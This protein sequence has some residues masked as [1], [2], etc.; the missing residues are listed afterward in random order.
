MI[1]LLCCFRTRDHPFR[2][3]AE[4]QLDVQWWHEFL[5]SWH[6]VSFWLFPG[7]SD[8]EVTSD[9][10]GSLGFGA[11]FNNEWFSGAWVPSQADQ[12]I[13]YKERFPVVV[14]AHVWVLSGISDMLSFFSLTMRPLYTSCLLGRRGSHA[15]WVLSVIYSLQLLVLILLSNHSIS[16]VFITTLLMLF[17]AFVGRIFGVWLPMHS[18]SQLQLLISSGSS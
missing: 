9:P 15:L 2:L 17:P 13:A 6:G 18:L 12:S 16:Q 11:Y 7:M 4:V 1:D 3:S 14:A 10:A 5:T 8:I